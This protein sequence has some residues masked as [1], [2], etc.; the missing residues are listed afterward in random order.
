M[1]GDR[2]EQALSRLGVTKERVESWVGKGCR[3]G[4]RKERLNQLDLWAR[5]V[6]SGKM[7]KAKEFLDSIVS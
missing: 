6:L 1:L 4:E 2:V 3:C 5:R 7:E